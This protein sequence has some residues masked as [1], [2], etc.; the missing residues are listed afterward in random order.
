MRNKIVL[1]ML[2]SFVF[3][4]TSAHA[5]EFDVVSDSIS[6]SLTF[7]STVARDLN[8]TVENISAREPINIRVDERVVVRADSIK[9]SFSPLGSVDGLSRVVDV[10]VPNVYS[11]AMTLFQAFY[12][13]SGI[14]K[15]ECKVLVLEGVLDNSHKARL[16]TFLDSKSVA[17]EELG[18]YFMFDCK[19]ANR[20]S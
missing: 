3:I 15:R 5:L 16:R 9:L 7:E 1:M 11:N 20:G 10:S 13:E 8:E 2:L 12:L 18:E 19:L 14:A 6:F 17:I 4:Q